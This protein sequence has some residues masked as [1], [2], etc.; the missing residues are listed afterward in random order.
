MSFGDRVAVV[1]IGL[2]VIASGWYP[3]KRPSWMF[4]SGL[5]DWAY[6]LYAVALGSAAILAGLLT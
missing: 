1:L 3:R 5:P 6:R 4:G 2:T